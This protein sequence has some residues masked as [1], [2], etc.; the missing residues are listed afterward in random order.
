MPATAMFSKL[1]HGVGGGGG[2]S[3]YLEN[4]AIGQYFEIGKHVS[5]AG[6]EMVWKIHDGVRRS[7]GK[8]SSSEMGTNNAVHRQRSVERPNREKCVLIGNVPF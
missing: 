2:A 5:S 7:D 1:K 8:I 4:N 3:G 6:P